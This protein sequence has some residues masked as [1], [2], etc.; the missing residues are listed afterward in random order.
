MKAML[1]AAGLGTRLRP[2]TDT[3][4]K[5]LVKIGEITLLEYAIRKLMHY[6]FNEICINVHHFPDMIINYLKDN[7]NFGA[8]I[9]ISDERE[10]LLDTGGGLKKAAPF[11]A[12][13]EPFL[14]YNV[15]IVSNINLGDML[16]YHIAHK[17]LC[18]LAVREINSFRYFLFNDKDELCGWRNDK[19]G[20][21]KI[22]KHA[23]TYIPRGFSGIQ[24][25]Q[26]EALQYLPGKNIFSLVEFYLQLAPKDNIIG[27]DHSFNL[28]TDVGELQTLKKMANFD[29]LKY[30]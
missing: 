13:S 6:G 21:E 22:S 29:L 26:P 18:T 4:P 20:E 24:I 27:Y 7:N 3:I 11:F 19:T 15:D 12:G 17:P 1:F 14:V 2:I 8:K 9:T 23:E 30:L 25:M 28:W 5:A 16:N 10:L